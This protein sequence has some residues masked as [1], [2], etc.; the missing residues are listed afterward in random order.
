MV[1]HACIR[2][3]QRQVRDQPRLYGEFEASLG[4]AMS[5]CLL[6]WR[7]R[8]TALGFELRAYSCKGGVLIT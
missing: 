1:E 4:Y 3:V 5:P 8:G 6:F 7:G 2:A